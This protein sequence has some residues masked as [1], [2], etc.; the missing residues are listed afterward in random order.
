MTLHSENMSGL[1]GERPLT[2]QCKHYYAIDACPLG[3]AAKAHKRELPGPA[4]RRFR[5][6]LRDLLAR[7]RNPA[8]PAGRGVGSDPSVVTTDQTGD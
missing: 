1:R 8:E 7:G 5:N 3:C 2:P 4:T 6:L